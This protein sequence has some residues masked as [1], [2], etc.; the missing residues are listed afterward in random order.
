MKRTAAAV[1]VM[2]LGLGSAACGRVER[3][4]D[5][6]GANARTASAALDGRV[7]VQCGPDHQPLVRQLGAGEEAVTQVV[8]VPAAGHPI[9]LDVEGNAVP[10]AAPYAP[11]APLRLVS[12]EVPPRAAIAE[13][14]RR[15]QQR[16]VYRQAPAPRRRTWKKSAAIVGGSTAGG[17]AIGALIDGKKGAAIGAGTGLLAGTV[18]DIATRD[19]R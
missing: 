1:G 9:P 5:A 2:T 11:A 6:A 7:T 16:V 19:K 14:V 13:P 18:Y 3:P 17:A 8:C 15:A 10:Y 12:S 4:A